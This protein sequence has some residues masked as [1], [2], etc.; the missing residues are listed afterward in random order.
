VSAWCLFQGTGGSR[1]EGLD[2]NGKAELE[3]TD[4]LYK[5]AKSHKEGVFL[6]DL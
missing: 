6:F 2:T 5:C 3:T 1:L 4:K